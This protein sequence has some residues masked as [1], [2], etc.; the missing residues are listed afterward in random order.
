MDV[1]GGP[2]SVAEGKKTN[3][4]VRCVPLDIAKM[5]VIVVA[6]ETVHFWSRKIVT[7]RAFRRTAFKVLLSEELFPVRVVSS[8]I[9]ICSTC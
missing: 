1:A 6:A 7:F 2:T 3:I 9:D 8:E 5:V 4:G